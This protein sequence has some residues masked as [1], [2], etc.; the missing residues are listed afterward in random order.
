[1]ASVQKIIDHKTKVRTAVT[2]ALVA[3]RFTSSADFEDVVIESNGSF[4]SMA[5]LAGMIVLSSYLQYYSPITVL[6]S[7]FVEVMYFSMLG[8][9]LFTSM[10]NQMSSMQAFLS[11]MLG[12]CISQGLFNK[13]G[14][15]E[16][17]V[18]APLF[19]SA[20]LLM[21][22]SEHLVINVASTFLI[23]DGMLHIIRQWADDSQTPFIFVAMCGALELLSKQIVA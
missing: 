8:L 17:A 12:F 19:I 15:N 4:N 14:F 2:V 7:F 6:A 21:R 10:T 5:A 22:G 23:I 18:K 1:M 3:A 16:S 20:G 9:V 13:N 11:I